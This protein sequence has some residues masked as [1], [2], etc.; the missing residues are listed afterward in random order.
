VSVP[1]DVQAT[2]AATLVDEWVAAGVSQ[3]VVC[4]GSRSTPLVLALAEREEIAVHV[5]LDERGACFFAVGLARATGWPALVCTT[6]GTAAAELHAG[7]VEASHDRVP[8]IVCTA[9]RPARL[10]H[11]GAPQTIEQ[12]GLFGRAVRRS[13]DPGVPVAADRGWWR[14]FAAS[15]VQ[16]AVE[17][18]GPVH[19]NLAFEEPLL[20]TA[21]PLPPPT[22]RP[23]A[24]RRWPLATDAAVAE[25]CWARPGLIVAGAGGPQPRLVL[26]LA[27]RLGWPVLADP[28]SGARLEHP[29]VIA[30]A[31]AILRDPEVRAALAPETVLLL[32]RPWASR[33]LA[34]LVET[35]GRNGGTVVAVGEVLDDPA[36]VVRAFHRVEAASF[37]TRL[38][39]AAR[40]VA[41]AWRG[42]WERAEAAAQGAID[43][44]LESDAL[45]AG[46]LATEPGIA[47]HLFGTLEATTVL[48]ASSS[49]PVRDLEW[50]G[51]AR[52]APPRVLANRGV[53]GIDGVVS[54]AL[55][56]AAGR[57]APVV[58]L[59][60][61]LAF[62]HDATSFAE[63]GADRHGS[64]TF[65]VLDNS[66]GGIFSFLPQARDLDPAR[67][68]QL[69]GT[70]PQVSVAS[71]GE[72]Y[73][74]PV[75]TVS[76][77]SGLDGALARFVGRSDRSL[78]VVRVPPRA[79]NARLHDR[80]DEA[81]AEAVGA[82]LGW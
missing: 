64:C 17:E 45:S 43:K 72:G 5:R 26:A 47:R 57:S 62:L 53:N 74:L 44:V 29:G 81:V 40:P 54:S 52:P 41:G 49:M 16:S 9:D 46:G 63:V 7:V 80:L 66:G 51:A 23:R 11:V 77:L 20:G 33:V 27:D 56:V 55:G 38:T 67:F 76:S 31:D 19:L 75:E 50:F 10:H 34:E 82:A 8:L 12:T 18:S 6:S 21:G 68:E 69:F 37:V 28:R 61:D 59:L 14:S 39:E 22:A 25:A 2:F 36:R 73:G 1:S 30:A 4:P 78:V 24:T 32:G 70:A 3:A 13:L 42:R 71:V 48:F 58:A 79:E 65:V 35:T 60:G 15:V